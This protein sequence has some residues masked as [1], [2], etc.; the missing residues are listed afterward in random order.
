MRLQLKQLDSVGMQYKQQT[1]IRAGVVI[2]LC[3]VGV[4]LSEVVCLLNIL[5][6]IIHIVFSF[7]H[8]IW[9]N[10]KVL[11]VVG[12]NTLFA[13]YHYSLPLYDSQVQALP[14]LHGIF[15]SIF[16]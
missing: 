8:C 1:A 15:M 14:Y 10:H 2:R 6:L 9:M 13:K 16:F 12:S 4:I 3:W 11:Y 5:L 7:K